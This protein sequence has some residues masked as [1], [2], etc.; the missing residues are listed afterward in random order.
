MCSLHVQSSFLELP[1][2]HLDAEQK[3]EEEHVENRA[4]QQL[5]MPYIK[6]RACIVSIL[7]PPLHLM[8]ETSTLPIAAAS[9]L[10]SYGAVTVDP[11]HDSLNLSEI[12]PD[13]GFHALSRTSGHIDLLSKIPAPAPTPPTLMQPW[14]NEVQAWA[15]SPLRGRIGSQDGDG[16][17]L[18]NL[19]SSS[20]LFHLAQHITVSLSKVSRLLAEAWQ[21]GLSLQ[22]E[23]LAWSSKDSA[24]SLNE[25]RQTTEISAS[26]LISILSE[27]ESEWKELQFSVQQ[28]PEAAIVCGLDIA[29]LNPSVRSSIDSLQAIASSA[30]TDLAA[31]PYHGEPTPKEDNHELPFNLQRNRPVIHCPAS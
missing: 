13:P 6:T 5:S 27:L 15:S 17:S 3:S 19:P 23:R 11:D 7:P 2:S 25:I 14:N 16:S 26:M 24:H 12:D 1:N 9:G 4:A 21:C 30:S 31:T 29:Q 28:Q 8:R 10:S 22:S 20:I 18:L